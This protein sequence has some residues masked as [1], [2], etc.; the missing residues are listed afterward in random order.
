MR[1]VKMGNYLEINWIKIMMSLSFSWIFILGI[2]FFNT[3]LF[4][5]VSLVILAGIA[6]LVID[7][8]INLSSESEDLGINRNVAPFVGAFFGLLL[9]V[10]VLYGLVAYS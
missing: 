3:D 9:N 6:Y 7:S 2:W 10:M 4:G 8:L 1:G 5:I